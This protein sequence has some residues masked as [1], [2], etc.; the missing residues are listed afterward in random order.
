MDWL[1]SGYCAS[2]RMFNAHSHTKAQ[3]KTSCARSLPG[4]CI[5][6]ILDWTSY[7]WWA[8]SRSLE[9]FYWNMT[10][11]DKEAAWGREVDGSQEEPP[12][13]YSSS[14][15]LSPAVAGRGFEDNRCLVSPPLDKLEQSL[16]AFSKC[17]IK[18]KVAQWLF[19]RVF[20]EVVSRRVAHSDDGIKI[21]QRCDSFRQSSTNTVSQAMA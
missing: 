9:K 6:Q 8:E 13:Q 14:V 19:W 16:R 12:L 11:F 5:S 4:E 21:K 15:R 7:R 17:F 18:S 2:Y 3:K 20:Y 10:K 1:I